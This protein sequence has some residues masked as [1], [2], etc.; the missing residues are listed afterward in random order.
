MTNSELKIIVMDGRNMMVLFCFIALPWIC[1][2]FLFSFNW[3]RNCTVFFSQLT[4][5]WGI[6]IFDGSGNM[7]GMW[8]TRT[9]LS[10]VESQVSNVYRRRGR[11]RQTV[12]CVCVC[13]DTI[14]VSGRLVPVAVFDVCLE[15]ERYVSDGDAVSVVHF[16]RSARIE[17]IRLMKTV[18]G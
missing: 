13:T 4:E 8:H 15:R 3:L 6:L 1:V 17:R 16:T 2:C 18:M 14:H 12:C 10:T 11:V 9:H 5:N 7:F